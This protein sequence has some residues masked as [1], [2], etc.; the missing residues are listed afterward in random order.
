[1]PGA[2]GTALLLLALAYGVGSL[3]QGEI[4]GWTP[5]EVATALA[6]GAALLLVVNGIARRF[7]F[8]AGEG[9]AALA[10]WLTLGAAGATLYAWRDHAH[11]LALRMIGEYAAGEPVT[12]AAGEVV[13]ARRAD[14]GFSVKARVNGQEQSFAFDTGASTVVLTAESAAAL[15]LQPGPQA[16]AVPVQTANGRTLAAPVLLDTVS[17]GPIRERRVSALVTRP[18]SLSVNLLGM[19]FLE[20][21]S[22]YEVRGGR[23]IL[24]GARSG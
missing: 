21:L 16:F 13:I 14:G 12:N 2:L 23:L 8:G 11:D 4:A 1:M 20:R 15:G 22:S 5:Q 10:V 9:L 18:G 6:V 3:A 24:R 17:V 7:R 19:S